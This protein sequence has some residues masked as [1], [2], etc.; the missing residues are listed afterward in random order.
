MFEV[1]VS[2]KRGAMR[3]CIL[4]AAALGWTVALVGVEAAEQRAQE[5][6][7]IVVEFGT[8]N[9]DLMLVPKTLRLRAG[10]LYRLVMRNPSGL[11]HYVSGPPFSTAVRTHRVDVSASAADRVWFPWFGLP[12]DAW[13]RELETKGVLLRPGMKVAWEFVPIRTGSFRFGC[14]QPHH[15]EAGMVGEI[16][17]TAPPPV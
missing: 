16:E 15:M 11:S 13:V 14:A 7:E 6:I 17:V 5:P 2:R 10:R 12:V 9:D 1:R 4:F 3:K 8:E